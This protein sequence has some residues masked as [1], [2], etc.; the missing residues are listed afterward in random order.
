MGAVEAVRR[1]F[2][3]ARVSDLPPAL[4]HLDWHL[5]N[6]LVDRTGTLLAVLDWEFA[7]ITDP[8]FD[9]ARFV[10]LSCWDGDGSKCRK[11]SRG[12]SE[13]EIW[14]KYSQCRF[15]QSAIECLG[16]LEPWIA[17][18]SLAV[19]VVTSA[20]CARVASGGSNHQPPE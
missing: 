19:L 9:L 14:E 18:E 13:K 4:G 6:V 20:V 1:T 5:G 8:R 11:R 17:L 3:T 7:G 15:R 16:P 2:A 10:R 12:P